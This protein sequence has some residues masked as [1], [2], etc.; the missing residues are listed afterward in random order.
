METRPRNLLV[1]IDGVL[2]EYN[3]E[4]IHGRQPMKLLPGT[5]EKLREWKAKGDHI[6]LL[7]GRFANRATTEKQLH[8][9]GITT[10]LYDELL[11]WATGGIRMLINDDKPD[12]TKT[13]IAHSIP[14]NSGIASINE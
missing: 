8:E 5:L 4:V 14:R 12:G 3:L 13:A 10:D 1:D 9:A 11:T 7:T 6:A 2:A